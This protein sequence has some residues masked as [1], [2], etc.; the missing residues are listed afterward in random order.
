MMT[1]EKL[2]LEIRDWKARS[3]HEAKLAFEAGDLVLAMVWG[4]KVKH[5]NE[6]DECTRR[7]RYETGPAI[8]EVAR[9]LK[10]VVER[11]DLNGYAAKAGKVLAAVPSPED[12]MKAMKQHFEID[13][14]ARAGGLRDLGTIVQKV[15]VRDVV[16]DESDEAFRARMRARYGM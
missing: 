11:I 16:A 12:L 4:A 15:I 10:N 1:K 8:D 5:L 2:R 13:L 9:G 3:L 14:N 7:H 6:L